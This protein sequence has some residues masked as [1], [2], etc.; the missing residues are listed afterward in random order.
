MDVSLRGFG[1]VEVV[2]IRWL[3]NGSF[4]PVGQVTTSNTGSANIDVTIPT[5]AV[6]GANTVRGDGPLPR[7]D[8]R[9]HGDRPLTAT[10][11]QAARVTYQPEAGSG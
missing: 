8:Q 10:T 1:R 5:G 7:R 4:V 3:I 6:G 9:R 11:R 2:Q